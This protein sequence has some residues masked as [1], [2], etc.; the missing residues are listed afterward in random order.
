MR[1]IL[2]ILVLIKISFMNNS[3]EK[4]NGD[5]EK[6]KDSKNHLLNSKN[7]S[8]YQN[9]E[10]KPNLSLDSGENNKF[11]DKAKE[12][13]KLKENVTDS[14]QIPQNININPSLQNISKNEQIENGD[15][16]PIL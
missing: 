8:H 16:L 4:S 7:D 15:N 12:Q 3:K 2:K 1:I 14:L 6:N 11:Q 5:K 10:Q 13:N 9:Q